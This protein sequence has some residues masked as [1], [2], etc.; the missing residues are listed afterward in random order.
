MK[1]RSK[2]TIK[3]VLYFF[4]GI[5]LAGIIYEQCAQIYFNAKK[6]GADEFCNINGKEIHFIKKGKGGPT[7][8][9]QSGR[10]GDYKIWQEI[11]DSLS[12]Y[13]T[14]I[15][16]DRAGLMWSDVS[17]ETRTLKSMTAE[18]EQLLE[19]TNCPKPYILVGHSLA[20]IT[21]RPFVRDH[22]N[23]ISAVIFADV[24]HPLQIKN[25][26]EELKKYLV[27]PPQW[28]IG[29]FIE[30][31]IARLYFSFKPFMTEL[32]LTHWMN[33]HVRDYFYKSY[34]A[35]LQEAQ[36]DD[37]MFEQAEAI[38]SFDP[39]PLT[40]ITGAYP[41]GA[42]FLGEESLVREYLTLHRRHQADLLHLSSQSKNVIAPHSGHYVPL[43]DPQIVIDAIKEY[44][45]APV[46]PSGN[47][48]VQ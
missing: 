37:I 12:G 17:N 24:S 39:I 25:A 31:G 4:S 28:L 38:N 3:Y 7:V 16:Y 1:K 26:S 19:K 41:D 15:S 18:L 11:Q 43:Q 46:V 29:T 2:Q 34:K 42:D 47:G 14:T 13:M 21:L 36:D 44:L 8:V 32:P 40:I 10:G 45:P 35:F 6:P 22:A 20:G 5:L 33:R 23:D 9:F 48:R 27:V 30:T